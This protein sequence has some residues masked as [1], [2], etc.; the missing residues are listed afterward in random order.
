MADG[1]TYRRA[2]LALG[3]GD[4]IRGMQ[5]LFMLA[6]RLE[7][8][9]GK[10]PWPQDARNQFAAFRALGDECEEVNHALCMETPDRRRRD[11]DNVCKACLDALSPEKGK[12]RG[13]PGVW[14]ADS[15][16]DIL[17]VERGPVHR[18]GG[19]VRVHVLEMGEGAS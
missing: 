2:L 19:Y 5:T 17:H 13:F 16:I 8:A 7:H 3:N 12:V 11:L 18:E 14:L 9:R 4:K 15:Q 6:A 10:H 1:M